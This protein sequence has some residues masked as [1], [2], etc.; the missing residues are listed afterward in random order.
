M[1]TKVQVKLS[2]VY[3]GISSLECPCCHESYLHQSIV[4]VYNRR[5]DDEQVRCTIVDSGNV[6]SQALPNSASNNPSSRRQGLIIHFE[7]EH[8]GDT[9]LQLRIAQHKGYTFMDWEYDDGND[10]GRQSQE[11]GR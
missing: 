7:C 10:T 2:E 9:D 3:S 8:C 6:H 4:E 11:E 1:R 5:E